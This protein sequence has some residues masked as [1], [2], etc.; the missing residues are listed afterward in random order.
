[1]SVAPALHFPKGKQVTP[2]LMLLCFEGQQLTQGL[3]RIVTLLRVSIMCP[4]QK[5]QDVIEGNLWERIRVTISPPE[6][7]FS[8][9]MEISKGKEESWRKEGSCQGDER[10]GHTFLSILL[11]FPNVLHKI[12]LPTS[13][14]LP[15][16]GCHTLWNLS[17]FRADRGHAL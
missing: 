17:A 4:G 16:H 5:T 1:M 6:R 10:E 3:P 8:K 7:K 14:E 2:T 9:Q 13:P 12:S 15:S 11:W